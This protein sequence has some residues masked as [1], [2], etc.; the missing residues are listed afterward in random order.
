VLYE[1]SQNHVVLPRNIELLRKDKKSLEVEGSFTQF[2]MSDG[3]IHFVFNFRDLTERLQLLSEIIR[4]QKMEATATLAGGIAHDFNNLIGIIIPYTDMIKRSSDLSRIMKYVEHISEAARRAAKLT[5]ELLNFVRPEKIIMETLDLNKIV[6]STADLLTA[7]ISKNVAIALDLSGTELLIKGESYQIGQAIMNLG[8]NARDAIPE[9]QNGQ[10]LIRTGKMSLNP[11]E[12]YL[13]QVPAGEYSFVE[14]SDTGV[15]IPADLLPKI[16]EPFFTTKGKD[17]GTGLGLSMVFS[18]V[19]NH[20]GTVKT[21]SVVGEGS[22][23]S[24]FFPLAKD[25]A[26]MHYPEPQNVPSGNHEAVL[27][28]DDVEGVRKMLE[29]VLSW[30]GYQVIEASGGI[31]ALKIF[32]EKHL[33]IDVVLLDM[34]MPDLNGKE[35]F[36]RLKNINSNVPVILT[37]GFVEHGKDVQEL[38]PMG[39][40]GFLK[41]P[42]DNHDLLM[43]I[44]NVIDQNKKNNEH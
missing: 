7:A 24:L 39:L 25:L 38:I 8:L 20:G 34:V 9:N 17:K 13:L 22:V 43:L 32:E 21:K 40:A 41:K 31:P 10:I 29:D 11:N 12:A 16:F 18:V 36:L 26:K 2:R 14:I 44:R 23:F 27:V 42:Y 37:S 4:S 6:K 1:L 5:R 35:T 15:G 30:H 33:A 19:K 28:V 3:K